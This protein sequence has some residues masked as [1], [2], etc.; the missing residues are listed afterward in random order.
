DFERRFPLHAA[1]LRQL[2]KQPRSSSA[3]QGG[4][5]NPHLAEHATPSGST[6]LPSLPEQ[7]G[8]YRIPKPLRRGGMGSVFLV[9]ATQLDRRFALKVPPFAPT[10]GPDVLERFYREA[11]AA[12]VL[13]HPNLCPVHDVGCIDGVHYLTMAFIEG[14]SLQQ[15]LADNP[16]VAP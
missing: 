1:A 6:G 11:R 10:D 14:E 8:R 16:K 3:A 12:A 13:D 4:T 2:L 5:P 15:R 9:H 7:F